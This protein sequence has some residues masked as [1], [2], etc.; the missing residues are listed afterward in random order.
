MKHQMHTGGKLGR[1][2]PQRNAMLKT[3]ITQ[4]I[5]HERIQTTQAKAQYVRG[6][7]E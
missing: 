1:S 4:M 7:L 2:G 5:Q 3:M 6:E